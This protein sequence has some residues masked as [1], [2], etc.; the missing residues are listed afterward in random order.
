M[1]CLFQNH[2]VQ[3]QNLLIK[4]PDNPIANGLPVTKLVKP[5]APPQ[6][7]QP[8]AQYQKPE[9]HHQATREKPHHPRERYVWLL[10][11]SVYH[12]A[13]YLIPTPQC[14]RVQ[15]RLNS[16]REEQFIAHSDQGVD[17]ETDKINLSSLS[18]I[19]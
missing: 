10:C 19:T 14:Y 4:F 6:N 5:A 13:G 1:K 16:N 11:S 18:N 7:Q 3:G 2:E 17:E 12:P 8:P 9:K 15:L